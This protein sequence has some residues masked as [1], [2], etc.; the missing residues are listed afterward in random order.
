MESGCVS[1]HKTYDG[2]TLLTN[3]ELSPITLRGLFKLSTDKLTVDGD[4][5]NADGSVTRKKK[6]VKVK[7]SD[8]SYTVQ[9]EN[10]TGYTFANMYENGEVLYGSI[11]NSNNSSFSIETKYEYS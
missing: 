10:C 3:T 9:G 5:Y 2:E 11:A 7:I 1:A 8:A 4:E 6:Y